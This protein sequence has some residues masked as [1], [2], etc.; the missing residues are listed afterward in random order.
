[1]INAKAQ[2]NQQLKA[3]ALIVAAFYKF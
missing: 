2:Y 3:S 1:M